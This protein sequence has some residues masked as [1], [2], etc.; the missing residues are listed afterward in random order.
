MPRVERARA[1]HEP[2]QPIRQRQN[3]G[4]GTRSAAA[5]VRERNAH[6]RVVGHIVHLGE[7]V[8]DARLEFGDAALLWLAAHHEHEVDRL[9]IEIGESNGSRCQL[10][11]I[12]GVFGADS[13]NDVSGIGN[14]GS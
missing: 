10:T 3:L 8:A 11:P 6:D 9:H 1:T 14:Q 4:K 12:V 7:S 5:G 2:P 13:A